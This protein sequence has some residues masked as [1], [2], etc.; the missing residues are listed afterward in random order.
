M[1]LGIGDKIVKLDKATGKPVENESYVEY[2]VVDLSPT[3][4]D[5]CPQTQQNNPNLNVVIFTK[6]RKLQ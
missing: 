4:N 3:F 2:E 5:N 1:T 6:L